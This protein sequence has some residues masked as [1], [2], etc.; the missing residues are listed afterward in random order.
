MIQNLFTKF[1]EANSNGESLTL[2]YADV[3]LFMELLG[4]ELAQASEELDHWQEVI[5]DYHRLENKQT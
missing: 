3:A 1:S 2:S 4:D 5:A